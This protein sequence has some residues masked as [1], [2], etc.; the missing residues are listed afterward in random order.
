[1][2]RSEQINITLGTAGHIDHGKTALVKCLTGCDTDRLKEEKERGMSIELG[3]APCVVGDLQVGIVDVPGHENFIKTMVAGASGID[4]VMLVVAA[5][6][7]VMPQTREHM[8]ILTL[9]GVRWGL[10]VLTKIDRVDAEQVEL[11]KAEVRGYL[12]ETFLAN[13]PILPVSN[14]TFDGLGELHEALGRMVRATRPRR[15]DGVFRLPVER[16]FTAKGYGTVVCGIPVS[17]QAV[18]GDEVVLLPH[19]VRGRVKTIQVYKRPGEVVLAGQCTAMN[20]P[21]LDR[22]TIERGHVIAAPGYFEARTWCVGLLRLLPHEGVAI[23]G[24]TRLKLHTGTSEL[25]AAAYP[26]EATAVE[27]GQE[28]LVQFRLE[29]PL[30][31]GPGDRFI[32][33]SL[34]PVRTIGGGVLIDTLAQRLKRNRP[35]TAVELRERVGA[36]GDDE[37]LVECRVRWAAGLAVG[38]KELAAE[39]K[40]PPARVRTIVAELVRAGKLL[41]FG[42]AG[43]IH[44]ETARTAGE[45]VLEKVGEYHR[46]SPESP[47][48]T[49]EELRTSIGFS[50]E[51]LEGLTGLLKGQGRLVQRN[52]R[53][54]LPAHR[55]TLAGADQKLFEAIDAMFR[56]RPF[57]PP[58]EDEVVAGTGATRA[59]VRRVTKILLEH[60]R[61][62]R[63]PEELLFHREAV[64][65][66]RAI[67]VGELKSAG[68]LESVRWKYLLD[69]T[70]KYAIPLL[71]YFDRI[72]VTRRLN[73]TRYLRT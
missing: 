5:D 52:Q 72:G 30:V 6:D 9:L 69:T 33:R 3:F 47:G 58:E 25:L 44:A 66:A 12:A 62:V 21:Q 20:I 34:T 4:A 8:D 65:K 55:E 24:G 28:A 22:S 54:A 56:G 14:V 70:R 32:V 64:E 19:N 37:A 36:V 27:A 26:L 59:D 53:W 39:V 29:A 15:T 35:P 10:I 38:E 1:M 67:L 46:Q 57:N 42:S 18:V 60:E 51:V 68:R 7:G 61:L 45:R 49:F 16:T 11:V 40:L 43:W 41:A 13:A 50:K 63:V 48:A 73:N 71:D 23:K 31:A 17:G 2:A